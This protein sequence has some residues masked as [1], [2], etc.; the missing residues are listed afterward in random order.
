MASLFTITSEFQYEIVRKLADG[1]MGVVYEAEQRGVSQFVKRVAIKVIRKELATKKQFLQNFIGEAKLVSDLVHTNIVQTYH[2]GETRGVYYIAME[3]VRG[4]NLER[5]CQQ[6]KASKLELPADLAVFIVSRITRGLAYAHSKT[7]SMGV[8]LN[9]VHR[10]I[11]PRNILVA[12]EGDVK[13]T[14]FGVAKAR[15]YLPDNEGEM[16]AGKADYIE[17]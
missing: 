9:I 13:I 4:S 12:G 1:G 2:L 16:I 11:N 8:P 14:D 3:L 10:D 6:L 17:S 15:G 5:F 7:D